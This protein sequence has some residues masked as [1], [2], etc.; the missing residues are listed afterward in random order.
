MCESRCGILCSQCE[1]KEKVGCTGCINIEK[2]FWGEVCRVK[3]CCE[4]KK[5]EQ[6]GLCNDFPCDLLKSFSYDNEQGDNG[7]RIEQCKQ[8]CL[9]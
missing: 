5:Y 2:P 8:W 6:C 7:K 3:E 4:N 1:Y 9:K